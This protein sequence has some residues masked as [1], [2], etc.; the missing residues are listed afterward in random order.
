MGPIIKIIRLH[1]A[2]KASRGQAFY[3]IV[4]KE[5]KYCKYDSC[6]HVHNSSFYL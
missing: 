2:G 6:G 5:M 3:H 4:M 1:Y